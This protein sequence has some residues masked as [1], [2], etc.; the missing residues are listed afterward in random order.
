[1]SRPVINLF[2]NKKEKFG[3]NNLIKSKGDDIL[4]N[5]N[6]FSNITSKNILKENTQK[7]LSENL[8]SIYVQNSL[9]NMVL[10]SNLD[11]N[12]VIK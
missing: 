5:K 2:L 10:N 1:M 6:L 3:K 7:N 11:N 4:I 9:D 8:S 12:N